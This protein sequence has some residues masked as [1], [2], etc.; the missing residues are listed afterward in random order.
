[1]VKGGATLT[2]VVENATAQRELKKCIGDDLRDAE[3]SRLF[4][5][6]FALVAGRSGERKGGERKEEGKKKRRKRIKENQYIKWGKSN[7]NRD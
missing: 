5:N 1:M 4:S 3:T 2:K 7:T 6:F